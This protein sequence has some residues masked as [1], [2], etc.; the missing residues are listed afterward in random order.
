MAESAD[1]V[2]RMQNDM[3]DVDE[4]G[5]PVSLDPPWADAESAD[6]VRRLQK[7]ITAPTTR[8]TA[9]RP[10]VPARPATPNPHAFRN[11]TADDMRNFRRHTGASNMNSEMDKWKTWQ[12]MQGNLNASNADFYKARSRGFR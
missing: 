6:M 5:M 12:A 10:S 3:I 9:T 1:M 8:P 11:I 2:R 7:S 4:N